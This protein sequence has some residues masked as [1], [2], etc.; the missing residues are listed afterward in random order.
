LF[1]RCSSGA[2]CILGKCLYFGRGAELNVLLRVRSGHALQHAGGACSAWMWPRYSDM[3]PRPRCNR[4]N[5]L[6]WET[7]VDVAQRGQ[8]C[9]NCSVIVVAVPRLFVCVLLCTGKA[10]MVSNFKLERKILSP[11][12][13]TAVQRWG[14]QQRTA[15]QKVPV[16]DSCMC[17]RSHC[18]SMQRYLCF[19]G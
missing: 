13:S 9:N 17:S 1:Q 16:L 12:A 6:Q 7:A 8:Q 15:L 19:C 5:A 11:R 2:V 4:N 3:H 18:S 10:T 14:V